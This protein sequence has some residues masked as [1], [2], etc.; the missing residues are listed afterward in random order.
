MT[1]TPLEAEGVPPEEDIAAAKMP[2][3]LET[4]P[5]EVPNAPNRDP[6]HETAGLDPQDDSSPQPRSTETTGL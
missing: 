2:E 3:Q 6:S 4:D 1:N 5:D